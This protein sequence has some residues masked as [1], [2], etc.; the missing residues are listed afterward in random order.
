MVSIGK[1]ITDFEL[2]VF[3]KG[4]FHEVKLSDYRGKWVVLVFY[5]ADFT[6]ICPTELGELADL[7]PEFQKAGAEVLSVS[8]DTAFCH[9]IWHEQSSTIGKID[10]PMVADPTGA[11]CREFGTYIEGEPGALVEDAGLSRRGSFLIDPDGV[12]TALEIHDNSIGRNA[13][14]LLRKVQAADFVRNSD[15]LVCPANWQP[16][17]DTLR[18]GADLVG[19]I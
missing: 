14:E 7:Y 9:K 13:S 19:K 6:F 5:P 3:H 8:T 4:G 17:A 10:F 15:G 16:N 2:E 12:L 1:E 18:P 11:L